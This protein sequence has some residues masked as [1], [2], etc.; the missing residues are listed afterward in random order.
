MD[1]YSH[2]PNAISCNERK[3]FFIHNNAGKFLHEKKIPADVVVVFSDV[4]QALA[5]IVI[6]FS[7]H[8]FP[9]IIF[10]VF[11]LLKHFFFVFFFLK[12]NLQFHSLVISIICPIHSSC[13]ATKNVKKKKTLI[14][15]N[16]TKHKLFVE[17]R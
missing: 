5:V 8:S 7:S 12:Q 4:S 14:W 1:F 11:L 13:E 10:F 17:T 6:S 16:G 2:H 15:L 9:T 3:F